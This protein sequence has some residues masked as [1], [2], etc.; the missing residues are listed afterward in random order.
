MRITEQDT[1][2][3]LKVTYHLP[4]KN[5]RVVRC[6]GYAAYPTEVG[7]WWRRMTRKVKAGVRK[8]AHSK[9]FRATASALE[10][11]ADDMPSPYKDYY[12]GASAVVKLSRRIASRVKAGDKKA[13]VALAR[14]KRTAAYKRDTRAA[15]ARVLQKTRKGSTARKVA[16]TA[17]A[18]QRG[19][20]VVRTP[21]GRVIRVPAKRVRS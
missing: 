7:G 18:R 6:V 1:G 8:V 17:L 19:A 20:Y 10:S 4:L 11:M 15:V 14:L 16:L 21:T 13:K 3:G 5:G 9:A 2:R 12:K